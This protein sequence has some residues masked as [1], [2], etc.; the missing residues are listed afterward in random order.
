MYV[1][2]RKLRSVES[3]ARVG[4]YINTVRFTFPRPC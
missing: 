4:I 2:E 3:T 1:V